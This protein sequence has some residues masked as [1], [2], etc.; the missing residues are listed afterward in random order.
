MNALVMV[1]TPPLSWLAAP[2]S[3]QAAPPQTMVLVPGLTSWMPPVPVCWMVPDQL[4]EALLLP[5]LRVMA[6]GVLLLMVPEPDSALTL[7]E[8]PLISQ[9]PPA[10]TVMLPGM[11]SARPA[12]NVPLSMM[13]SPV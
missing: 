2:L 13:V 8:N 10:P 1:L 6:V 4:M 9:V 5:T 3:S 11:S 7:S 12:V